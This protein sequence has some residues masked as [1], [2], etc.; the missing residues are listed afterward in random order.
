MDTVKSIL[1]TASS[2]YKLAEKVKANRKRCKRISDRVKALEDIV[3]SITNCSPELETALRELSLTLDSAQKLIEKYTAANLVERILKSGNHGDE[4]DTVSERLNDGYQVL[5]L[6]LHLEQRKRLCEVF[7]QREK[8]DE[9]D[10]KE[11][12]ME[13]TKLLMDYMQEQQEKTNSILRQLEKVVQMLNKPSFTN[14]AIQQI[15]PDKLKY[16]HPKKPFK[17]TASSEIYKGEYRGFPVAI[18]RYLNPA[19]TN[20][21]EVKSIFNKEVDTMKQFESPNIL[22]MFGIC[23]QDD[24]GPSPQFFIIMEYC[25]KGS[26][27]QVLDSDYTLSWIRRAR[28]CLDAAQGLYRLHN[29]EDKCKVHGCIKSSKFLVTKDYTVKLGGFRLAKTVTSLKRQTKDTTNRSLWYY[30]P[31]KLNDANF[32]YCKE[33]EMYSFGIVLWEIATSQKPF[34]GFSTKDIYNKVCEEKYQEPL[35]VD[36]PAEL[37]ELINACRAY[38]S[39]QRPSA[40][41]LVDKLRSMVTQLEEQEAY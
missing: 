31:E 38:D 24:E 32:S 13:M 9:V 23:I 21:G 4:F 15:Q 5:C 3:K 12:N 26:L 16:E 10:G 37:G 40:G 1:S 20:A 30:C 17:T 11:D 29:T 33:W 14:V 35:P 34:E 25:E 8:E 39:F 22:R 6:A 7:K 2:I 19:N 41:V 27:R 36:C 18:K 28:M